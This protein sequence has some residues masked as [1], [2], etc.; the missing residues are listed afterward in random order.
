MVH[1]QLLFF[2]PQTAFLSH[3]LHGASLPHSANPDQLE[4]LCIYGM[5]WSKHSSSYRLSDG[6]RCR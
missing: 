1:K 6:A 2:T 3:L 5:A 4:E